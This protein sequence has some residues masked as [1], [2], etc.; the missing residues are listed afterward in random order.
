MATGQLSGLPAY[1]EFV[2]TIETAPPP[3]PRW[4]FVIVTV[5]GLALILVPL[6]T[7]MFPRAAKGQAMIAAFGP[8]VTG[9]SIDAYRGD[10]RVL[11]DAR[12]NLLT[13]RA[14]GLEPGRYDRVD[15]FVHDYPDIRSDISGM[16][17]AIDANRGNYQRLADLPPL[18][19]LP[20]LL[21]LPGLVLV[22]AGVLGYRRAV[23]GRRAVAWA[24]VAGLA[25]AAL[26]AIP[27][28]GGLFSASS[29]GQPLI[30]GFRPILTHDKVRRVQGYFV[31]LVAADGELNS[32]YTAEVR[33][34]HPQ[35]DLTGITVLESR[36]Q[37]MTSRFAALIGAMNDEV[38]DFDAVVALND[39]TRPLGFGAFRALGWFYLVPGAIALT[40][41]AAGVRT[42]SSESGGERP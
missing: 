8:Y 22:A 24:S 2:S 31:T 1:S 11:D 5:L 23:S 32:R 37:P 21:A 12:T 39:T 15:R 35:A 36:W 28:A 4:P 33:A 42:R 16:V 9:S 17:D 6:V 13:L 40:V 25:G 18:G 19:A 7:G 30:D 10:L 27:L 3:K 26:I 29:A 20:W 38:R 41:A 14:Q 34:A